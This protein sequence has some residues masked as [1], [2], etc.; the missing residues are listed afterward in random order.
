MG[1]MYEKLIEV[2][3]DDIDLNGH[4]HNARYLEYANHARASYFEESDFP[5]SRM[6]QAGLGPVMFSEEAKYRHELFLGQFVTL[7]VQVVGMSADASRWQIL[8]TF[9][10]PDGQ[11][12]ASL[13]SAGAWVDLKTRKVKAPPPEIRSL[14][15]AVRSPHCTTIG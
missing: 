1:D 13:T 8:H 10:R 7:K 2:R 12:A 14:M 4:L 6:Y 11:Q 3:I 15:D 5:V 9:L